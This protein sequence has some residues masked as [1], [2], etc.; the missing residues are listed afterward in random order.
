MRHAGLFEHRPEI[1]RIFNVALVVM[2]RDHAAKFRL[3]Q[4]VEKGCRLGRARQID[5]LE[6]ALP[7][8]AEV[9]D[10]RQDRRDAD[11]ARD[12]QIL[13]RRNQFEIVARLGH[14]DVVALA[15]RIDEIHRA[16]AAERIALDGNAIA[17]PLVRVV[18]Q[19][20]FAQVAVGNAQGN[21]SARAKGRQVAAVRA[22]QLE[23]SNVVCD[24]LFLRDA[25]HLRQGF[26][27]HLSSPGLCPL[28]T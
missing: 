21:M 9:A 2:D 11:A 25:Q 20:I 3:L 23:E 5:Q 19:G 14:G 10:H 1:E 4:L 22:A 13:R 6:L 7:R 18:A 16:A 15:R 12:E 17:V 26:R 8:R 24:I 28:T 27:R